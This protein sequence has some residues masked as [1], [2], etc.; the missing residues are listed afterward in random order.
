MRFCS[1]DGIASKSTLGVWG[2]D[3]RPEEP[4]ALLMDGPRL[5]ACR[6]VQRIIHSLPTSRQIRWV[7][8]MCL[9]TVFTTDGS[10]PTVFVVPT[11]SACVSPARILF[12]HSYL[13]LS[14]ISSNASAISEVGTD[15]LEWRSRS[16][17][18][19]TILSVI[20]NHQQ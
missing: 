7:R 18:F 6:T 3:G 12:T 5:N 10:T 11:S 2:F 17:R 16:R 13:E 1:F 15:F 14:A 20:Q 4:V 8:I 19:E 9:N